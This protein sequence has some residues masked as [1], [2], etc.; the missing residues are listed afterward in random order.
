MW[1]V[2]CSLVSDTLINC[3]RLTE[4]YVYLEDRNMVKCLRVFQNNYYTGVTMGVEQTV[5]PSG[6]GQCKGALRVME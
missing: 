1:K 6:M 3:K 2:E 4:H 5:C